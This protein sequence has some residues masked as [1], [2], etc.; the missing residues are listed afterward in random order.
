MI[1]IL[2]LG[3]TGISQHFIDLVGYP[4]QSFIGLDYFK[5]YVFAYTGDLVFLKRH[6]SLGFVSIS[7]SHVEWADE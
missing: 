6:A 3:Y 5:W 4:W 7:M 2:W 1:L